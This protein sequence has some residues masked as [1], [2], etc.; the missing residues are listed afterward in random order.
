[1]SQPP[2]L[3]CQNYVS[4]LGLVRERPGETAVPP[5]MLSLNRLW[6]WIQSGTVVEGQPGPQE[7]LGSLSDLLRWWSSASRS[8]FAPDCHPPATSLPHA[9]QGAP[10]A[11]PAPA[12]GD[13]TRKQHPMS[14]NGLMSQECHGFVF[15]WLACQGAPP[16]RQG[17]AWMP[18]SLPT[19]SLAPLVP[20]GRRLMLRRQD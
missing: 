9:S 13:T 8:L 15:C 7:A 14:R 17:R 19:H 3:D 10:A 11:G 16:S 6:S 12:I 18:T 1:M 20:R 5:Q 2:L 4:C